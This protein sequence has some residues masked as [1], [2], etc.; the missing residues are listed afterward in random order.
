MV[1]KLPKLTFASEGH[2]DIEGTQQSG[3]LDLKL[4]DIVKDEKLLRYARNVAIELLEKD[5][6][7]AKPENM[8]IARRIAELNKEKTN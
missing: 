3:I 4:A 1:L 8:P 5:P 6:S 2:G 7:L